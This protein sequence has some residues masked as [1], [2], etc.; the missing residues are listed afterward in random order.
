MHADRGRD[1]APEVVK[2]YA[3][4][5]YV[6]QLSEAIRRYRI[7]YDLSQREFGQLVGRSSFEVAQIESGRCLPRPAPFKRI[8]ILLHW[9][10]A[11][12]GEVVLCTD[13][14]PMRGAVDG[15]RVEAAFRGREERLRAREADL[16]RREA[17]LVAS[18][19]TIRPG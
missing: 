13:V 15:R 16:Q 11:E 5:V 3:P 1:L 14:G 12:I 4:R 10:L 19:N 18:C 6:N 7:E 9:T 17:E 2:F 8:A